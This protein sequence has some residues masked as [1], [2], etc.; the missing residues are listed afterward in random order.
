MYFRICYTMSMNFSN[1]YDRPYAM[2]NYEMA[3]FIEA[4]TAQ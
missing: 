4:A 3:H 1:T 2:K